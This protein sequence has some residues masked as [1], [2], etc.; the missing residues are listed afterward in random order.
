MIGSSAWSAFVHSIRFGVGALGPI[1]VRNI[2]RDP[3]LRWLAFYPLAITLLVRWGIQPLTQRLLR[4]WNFD[5]V[6]YYPLCLSF[7]LM[8]TPMLTGMVFGFLLL[9]ERDDQTLLALQVT[10]LTLGGYLIYR[11]AV[12]ILFSILVTLIVLP[13]VALYHLNPLQT[14]LAS[15][16]A[17]PL[18]PIYALSL[19]AVA[20]NKVQG[21]ALA[22]AFGGFLVPPLVAYFID[23]PWQ[24]LC[25][26]VPFYWPA[27]FLWEMA[28]GTAYP[29]VYLVIGLIYQAGLLALLWK[30]F[31]LLAH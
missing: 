27:K 26:I 25:G 12:P 10:P 20:S 19:A 8:M 15:L 5:L 21:F 24:W 17:A 16:A 28:N 1:D 4:D 14:L 6:P 9:D 29:W 13:G 2:R 11:M 30:R 7:L 3:L 23:I 31:R 22:K 18:A